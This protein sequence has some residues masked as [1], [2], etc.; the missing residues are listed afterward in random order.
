MVK[1]VIEYL[2]EQ[3]RQALLRFADFESKR[4]E[5]TSDETLMVF[6]LA[7]YKLAERDP[8][9]VARILNGALTVYSKPAPAPK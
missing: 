2:S 4:L 7:L 6:Q 5:K 9:R 8:D 3:Q 1:P